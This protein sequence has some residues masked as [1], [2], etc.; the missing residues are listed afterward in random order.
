[1]IITIDYIILNKTE[2]CI[3]NFRWSQYMTFMNKQ[4]A[5]SIY[6]LKDSFVLLS[7]CPGAHGAQLS[8][9]VLDGFQFSIFL[10]RQQ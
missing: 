5:E 7:Y 3:W 9:L 2:L 10:Y 1:M 4:Q 8:E 6:A